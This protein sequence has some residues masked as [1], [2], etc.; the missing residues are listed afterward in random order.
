MVLQQDEPGYQ[1]ARI[2]ALL[3]L[4]LLLQPS[5]QPRLLMLMLL[6]SPY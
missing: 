4:Q 2:P 1:R 5:L 6:L 3:L